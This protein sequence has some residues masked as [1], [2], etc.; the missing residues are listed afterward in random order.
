[1]LT[2]L[3]GAKYALILTI[4]FGI[5][6]LAALAV[7]RIGGGK[8]KDALKRAYIATFGWGNWF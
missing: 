6:F 2:F 5:W 7:I 4:A 3:W 1:M 8:G